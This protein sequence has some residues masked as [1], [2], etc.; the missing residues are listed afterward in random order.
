MTLIVGITGRKR[1]GKDTLAAQLVARAPQPIVSIAFADPLREMLYRLNPYIRHIPASNITVPLFRIIDVL[2]WEGV[3][4][5]SYGDDVRRLLQRLGTEAVRHEDPD[6]WVRAF[7]RRVD[8]LT[9]DTIVVVPDVRFSNEAELCDTVIRVERPDL[10]E[11][12][13]PHASEDVDSLHADHVLVN[14]GTP[15]DLGS[16]GLRVLA[17]LFDTYYIWSS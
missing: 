6:F 4:D 16:K 9:P 1:S 5:T 15:A 7:L 2:G 13:D 11:S 14:D 8:R 3:K 17:P 10:G 12:T